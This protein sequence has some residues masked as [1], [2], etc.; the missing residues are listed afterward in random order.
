M[1]RCTEQSVLNTVILTA[2]ILRQNSVSL[3]ILVISACEGTK[4]THDTDRLVWTL[5]VVAMHH[6]D[7]MHTY[8]TYKDVCTST[9]RDC[10]AKIKALTLTWNMIHIMVP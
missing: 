4:E 9:K 5:L 3:K 7:N 8:Y 10:R 6:A 1:Q 2:H